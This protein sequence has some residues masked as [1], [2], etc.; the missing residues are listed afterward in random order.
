MLS[1]RLDALATKVDFLTVSRLRQ[2]QKNLAAL[3]GDL[4]GKK[5]QLTEDGPGGF[6]RRGWVGSRW[7]D[8]APAR[9]QVS[10]IRPESS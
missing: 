1:S 6:P 2:F 8:F 4:L 9:C 7:T 3:L 10:R 5:I